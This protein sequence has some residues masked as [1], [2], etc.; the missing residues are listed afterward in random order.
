[1]NAR[2]L[3]GL[4]AIAVLVF[5]ALNAQAAQLDPAQWTVTDSGTGKNIAKDLTDGRLESFC[6]LKAKGEDQPLSVTI[7]LKEAHLLHRVYWCGN[8]N[9]KGQDVP[10]PADIWKGVATR[11][12]ILAG[13]SPDSLKQISGECPV[14]M[15][16]LYEAKWKKGAGGK[17]PSAVNTEGDF[18]FPPR[19]ARY[20][21]LEARGLPAGASW[22]LGEVEI[23]GFQAEGQEVAKRE[24]VILPSD[25]PE[26]L[27][28]AAR[29]LSYYLGEM[30]G[31]PVPVATPDAAE[32]YSGPIF[33]IA[34]LKSLAGSYD[35]MTENLK[36]GKLPSCPVNVEAEGKAVVFKAWPYRN[37]LASVWAFLE[38]QG[39]RWTYPDPHGDFVPRRKELDMKVLPLRYSPSAERIYANFAV[40]EFRPTLPWELSKGKL[41]PTEGYLYFWRNHWSSSWNNFRFGGGQ[42]VPP[43]KGPKDST[44]AA[45]ALKD[46]YKEG[47]D[48]YP[49]NLNSVVPR[50]ILEAHPDW[51]GLKKA[52]PNDP[53]KRS[54]DITPCLTGE[55]LI[56]FVA[57]K[58]AA[59]AALYPGT[60]K[61]FGLLPMDACR[62]CECPA[63]LALNQPFV[64]PDIP[65][66][67]PNPYISS[68]SYYHFVGEVAR[69]AATTAANANFHALAYAEVFAPPKKIDKLPGNVIVEVCS[70][71]HMN[72]PPDS[73]RNATMKSYLEEWAKK[74]KR[75]ETYGYVLLNEDGR[76]WPMPLPL[77]TATVGWAKLQHKLGALPGGTQGS[78][79]MI[80][81]CPWNF[82]AYPRVLWNVDTDADALLKEFFSCYFREAGE[83]MLSYYKAAEDYQIH[84]NGSLY[85]GG[86]TYRLTPGAFPF[87]VLQEMSRQLKKG[88]SLASGRVAKRRLAAMREGFDWLVASTG[89]GAKR[90]EKPESFPSVGPGKPPL[91]VLMKDADV[92]PSEYAR[93]GDCCMQNGRRFGHFVRFETDGDYI[94]SFNGTGYT[95]PRHRKDRTIAAYVNGVFTEPQ[96]IP[97]GKGEHSF[98]VKAAQGVWEVGI[99]SMVFGEGPFYLKEFT[100]K[101]KE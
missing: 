5:P 47:F 71:G 34:D 66:C 45:R 72:L 75:L 15:D 67:A 46:E 88:E 2:R 95:E 42:E 16:S 48:G 4:C 50:R 3:R 97:D 58:A 49:H 6:E 93:G 90:I 83:A 31:R 28:L 20:V 52:G 85:G 74:C 87:Q 1:M 25:A 91:T 37:A 94:V 96:P 101:P 84:N 64:K 99:Q 62:Y 54:P 77:V 29:D 32:A 14:A 21:K 81:Y 61:S 78:P 82:Y 59:W 35:E 38:S 80:R 33:R 51:M 56:G 68:E 79:E 30:L 13:E 27:S 76:A 12:A 89:V 11:V 55:G 70:Y 10:F 63:C 92:I 36:S 53:G 7:D 43:A 41:L 17:G 65:Y 18:R 22:T 9:Y 24:A 86:Y 73:P 40:E 39:V 57:E 23:Y 60:Q 69:R 44:E 98:T 26:T 19:M 100:I 8:A